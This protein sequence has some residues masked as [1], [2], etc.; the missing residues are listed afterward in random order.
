MPKNKG[1][2]AKKTDTSKLAKDEGCIYEALIDLEGGDKSAMGREAISTG[3]VVEID[4]EAA[5]V[6][7]AEARGYDGPYYTTGADFVANLKTLVNSKAVLMRTGDSK[8]KGSPFKGATK[9][10]LRTL[11]MDPK[12]SSGVYWHAIGVDVAQ[13]TPIWHDQQGICKKGPAQSDTVIFWKK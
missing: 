10:A 11:L 8:V 6:V 12:S 5:L 2:S 9:S 1:G 13:K 3:E 4:D 7:L